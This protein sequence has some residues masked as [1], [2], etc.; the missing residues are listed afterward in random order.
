MMT[1]MTMMTSFGLVSGIR[2][3]LPIENGKFQLPASSFQ[4]R[5]SHSGMRERERERETTRLDSSGRWRWKRGRS[6]HDRWSSRPVLKPCPPPSLPREQT[7]PETN[8]SITA[9]QCIA[10][11]LGL[12]LWPVHRAWVPSMECD[13][14]REHRT[15]R[16]QLATGQIVSSSRSRAL[17]CPHRPCPLHVQ[18]G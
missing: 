3:P 12:C 1:V 5:L 8:N 18:S 13:C 11:A 7:A 16:P 4:D 17:Q 10:L 6:S 9:C 14:G 2:Y 15:P